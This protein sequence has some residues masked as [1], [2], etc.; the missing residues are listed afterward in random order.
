MPPEKK[1]E[2]IKVTDK[3]LFTADGDLREEYQGTVTPADPSAT[4]PPPPRPEPAKVKEEPKR[5]RKRA[6]NREPGR[7]P[8]TPF[9]N[10][11]ESLILNAYMSLGLLKN[12]YAVGEQPVDLAAARHM[13]EMLEMLSEKTAGNLTEDEEDFLTTHVGEL[14][15][16][17]VQI[18][19]GI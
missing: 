3:R 7:S 16:K 12:P 15:L 4:P 5:D 6:A 11:V 9:A 18:N 13:I 8:G 1:H 14:K 10:F 19:K 17:F 2:P